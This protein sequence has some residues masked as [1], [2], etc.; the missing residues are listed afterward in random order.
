MKRPMALV[1]F[2]TL[3]ALLAALFFGERIS[4]FLSAV[5]LVFFTCSLQDHSKRE[6]N[7]DCFPCNCLE[8]GFVCSRIRA[9]LLRE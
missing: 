6:G 4:L 3:L 2:A 8:H 9:D 7:S 5:S 1:G